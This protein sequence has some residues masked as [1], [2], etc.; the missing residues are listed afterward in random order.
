ML[1][2]S[3]SRFGCVLKMATQRLLFTSLSKDEF[4]TLLEEF[5]K[6]NSIKE[7]LSIHD[8]S[9]LQSLLEALHQEPPVD[10]NKSSLIDLELS[11]LG[12]YNLT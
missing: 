4:A 9:R 10:D 3:F 6:R 8:R 7:S 12:N 1:P 2:S 11:N 5:L